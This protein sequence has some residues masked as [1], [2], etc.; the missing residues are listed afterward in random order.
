[1]DARKN[2]RDAANAKKQHFNAP[3]FVTVEDNAVLT[4]SFS[5][6]LRPKPLFLIVCSLYNTYQYEFRKKL[7]NYYHVFN[8][9][10][11]LM[12]NSCRAIYIIPHCSKWYYFKRSYL[13][14]KNSYVFDSKF[15]L[16]LFRLILNLIWLN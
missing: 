1:M 5:I 10:K 7:V 12:H 6:L 4:F 2:A 16:L 15:I 8:L 13:L 11:Q 3:H 9:P 14:I